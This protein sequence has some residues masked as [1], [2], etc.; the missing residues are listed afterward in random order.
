M[1]N[2][3]EARQ[4]AGWTELEKSYP[5]LI[6][7]VFHALVTKQQLPTLSLVKTE[8]NSSQ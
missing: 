3:S 4:S 8:Q 1:A 7:D 5:R 2:V 6:A